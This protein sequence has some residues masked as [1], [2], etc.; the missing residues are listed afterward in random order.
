MWSRSGFFT[1]KHDQEGLP[2]LLTI[3]SGADRAAI[4][5]D[6][7]PPTGPGTPLKGHGPE[8][9]TSSAALLQNQ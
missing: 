9:A 7:A 2:V 6:A 4:T 5:I 1:S 3:V 8:S